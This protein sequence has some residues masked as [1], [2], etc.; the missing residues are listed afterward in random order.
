M[1]GSRSFASSQMRRSGNATL[2]LIARE[3]SNPR[4][5]PTG[6][7]GAE[8]RAG[9]TLRRRHQRKRRFVRARA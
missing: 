5:Q 3:P 6:R 7:K 4:M 1:P 9:G 8:F 2:R